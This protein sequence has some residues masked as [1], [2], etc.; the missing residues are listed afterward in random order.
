MKSYSLWC[1]RW[2]WGW[3]LDLPTQRYKCTNWLRGSGCLEIQTKWHRTDWQKRFPPGQVVLVKHQ[4]WPVKQS[5]LIIFKHHEFLLFCFRLSSLPHH[6]QAVSRQHIYDFSVRSQCSQ[7][8]Q[9]QMNHGSIQVSSVVELQH[10]ARPLSMPG[11]GAHQWLL[12]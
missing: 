9:S 5:P 4:S 10:R 11:T 7:H 12:S 6:S 1:H 3:L 2:W 8:V